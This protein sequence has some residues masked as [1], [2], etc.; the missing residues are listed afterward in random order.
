MTLFQNYRPPPAGRYARTRIPR[1]PSPDQR[2]QSDRGQP[3]TLNY[4][5]PHAQ[6]DLRHTLA[7]L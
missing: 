2:M 1:T 3:A 5:R 4:I 6:S 7:K